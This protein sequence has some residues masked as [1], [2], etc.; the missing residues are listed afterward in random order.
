[1][2]WICSVFCLLLICSCSNSVYECDKIIS[3][4]E[5]E[6][7]S[8]CDCF[9]SLEIIELKTDSI[10]FIGDLSDIKVYDNYFLAH[11]QNSVVYLFDK[12]GSLISNSKHMLGNARNEYTLLFGCSY[13]KYS[14]K[15]ELLSHFKVLVCNLNFEVE[16]IVRLPSF[17][18]TEEHKGQFYCEIFDLSA[19]RHYLIP[20]GLSADEDKI[21]YFDSET[22]ESKVVLSVY[23]D[24]WTHG[25]MQMS[26][27]S[28]KNEKE[29]YYAPMGTSN[30]LYSIDTEQNVLNRYAR[31]DFGSNGLTLDDLP[32][33]VGDKAG[34]E[35][36]KADLE[37][38]LKC[39]RDIP[40]R[41]VPNEESILI[42]VKNGYTRK[43]FYTLIYND[44]NGKLSKINMYDGTKYAFPFISAYSEGCYYA[45]VRSGEVSNFSEAMKSNISCQE[46]DCAVILKYRTK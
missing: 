5:G 42:L 6:V 9:S 31:L 22:E 12:N 21:T 20:S 39:D 7:V 32:S 45:L 38:L 46:E 2:R 15:I 35:Y 40:V 14:N 25:T 28:A 43:D 13:N 17:L 3:F 16:K 10:F 41:V 34:M 30:Y 4:D 33:K 11:D 26:C 29:V 44:V 18:P 24:L 37:Y 1:M 19:S 27:F 36:R 23:D 8:P